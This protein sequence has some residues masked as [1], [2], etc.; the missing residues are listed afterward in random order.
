MLR[1]R[2]SLRLQLCLIAT[3]A[4]LL[5]VFTFFIFPRALDV[6]ALNASLL[7][8]DITESPCQ[9]TWPFP[10]DFNF[11]RCFP[12]VTGELNLTV[13]M[14]ND[15]WVNVIVHR[16]RADIMFANLT[17]GSFRRD[18]PLDVA[19]GKHDLQQTVAI[20][21]VGFDRNYTAFSFGLLQALKLVGKG[22]FSFTLVGA[23]DASVLGIPFNTTVSIPLLL[24]NATN[25]ENM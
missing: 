25:V 15:N 18:D 14:T 19:H 21:S 2:T 11:T 17:L 23:V 10:R 7:K 20:S 16:Y 3:V 5:A 1:M 6:K 24:T 4:A 22:H 12:Q 9:I 8:F 13:Q